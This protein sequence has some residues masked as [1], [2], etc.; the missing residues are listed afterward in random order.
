M[1][2]QGKSSLWEIHGNDGSKLTWDMN[3]KIMG[4]EA[5]TGGDEWE[6]PSGKLQAALIWKP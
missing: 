1:G 2:I 5:R 4:L 3:G 6:V